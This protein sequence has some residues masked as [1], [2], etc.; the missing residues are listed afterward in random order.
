MK[1]D[2][3]FKL[4]KD[5]ESKWFRKQKLVHQALLKNN[6]DAFPPD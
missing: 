2:D 4:D 5:I 1:C 6:E 3:Y